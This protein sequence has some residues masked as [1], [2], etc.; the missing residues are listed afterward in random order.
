MQAYNLGCAQKD[1]ARWFRRARSSEADIASRA[2][3][4]MALLHHNLDGVG[5]GGG[6]LSD[7]VRE[8]EDQQG[9]NRCTTLPVGSA[10]GFRCSS[11]ITAD[12]YQ[13]RMGDLADDRK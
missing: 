13:D 2:F 12:F 9:L 11:D 3:S 1:S 4:V 6:L 10:A 5:G 8:S 7:S